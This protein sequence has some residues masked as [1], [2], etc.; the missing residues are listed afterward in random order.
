MGKCIKIKFI[1]V[2]PLSSLDVVPSFLDIAG[3]N[4]PLGG[5]LVG[6]WWA[7]GGRPASVVNEELQSHSVG[8]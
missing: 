7:T 5:V 8:T 2:F 6:E 1:S 3:H 4:L